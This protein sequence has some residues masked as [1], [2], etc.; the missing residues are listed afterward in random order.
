MTLESIYSGLEGASGKDETGK[1]AWAINSAIRAEKSNI[2]WLSCCIC[3]HAVVAS[4]LLVFTLND[5]AI[6]HCSMLRNWR[7]LPC[8]HSAVRFVQ[9]NKCL[10]L[11]WAKLHSPRLKIRESSRHWNR[12]QCIQKEGSTLRN[13]SFI[14]ASEKMEK[15][16]FEG[17]KTRLRGNSYAK[18]PQATLPPLFVV[19][20]ASRQENET[21]LRFCKLKF[22]S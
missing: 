14:L 12:I 17:K 16:R 7:P 10:H 1:R 9:R 11:N 8:S 20:I 6:H 4:D 22:I 15:T 18:C 21:E 5:F 2:L 19:I 13:L 3:E